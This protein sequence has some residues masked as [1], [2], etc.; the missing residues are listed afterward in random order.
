MYECMNRELDDCY[1][2]SEACFFIVSFG[3]LWSI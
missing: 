3:N 2:L 1:R